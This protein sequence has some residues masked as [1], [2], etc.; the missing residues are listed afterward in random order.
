MQWFDDE[1]QG[2]E[3]ADNVTPWV[4]DDR[5]VKE[6][7]IVADDHSVAKEIS[8]GGGQLLRPQDVRIFAS[9]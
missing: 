8:R 9:F 7:Q 4:D 2:Q 5:Y 6:P 3:V 1:P